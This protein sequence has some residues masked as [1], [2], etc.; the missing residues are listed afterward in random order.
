MN[1]DLPP[2]L[3]AALNREFSRF[4]SSEIRDAAEQLSLAYRGHARIRASLT[5]VERAAYLAVRFPSTFAA[6]NLVW[7]E[8]GQTLPLDGIATVLDV[9]SGPGTAALAAQ[10]YLGAA[11][12][13]T[14][15]ERDIGWRDVAGRL[16]AACALEGSFRQGSVAREIDIEPHDAVVA[17]YAL[18]EL[19]TAERD[20]S[21][22]AL[23]SLAKRVLVVIEPGTP[24]GFETIQNVRTHALRACGHAAAPCTHD[25]N[26]P[27]TTADWCHRPV[28]VARSAA[29]RAAKRADLGYEDEK[30]AYVVMSRT[31]PLRSAASR[32]VRKPIRNKGHVH[33]DVCETK[34]MTRQTIA[35]SDGATYRQARDAEWGG[36]WPPHDD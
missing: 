4:S 26:C 20:A 6:A 15:F 18:G 35:R 5:S 23:W 30:L 8:T 14:R 32:I 31:P 21:I 9:G 19:P 36:V 3:A 25:A 13:F 22:A 12:H 10:P 11:T 29:H 17:C 33:L 1:A 27:M 24:K 2:A 28:R 34:G 16:A 7:K